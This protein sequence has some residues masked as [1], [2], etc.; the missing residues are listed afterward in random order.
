MWSRIELAETLDPFGASS[1]WH[2]GWSSKLDVQYSKSCLRK[3]NEGRY[4]WGG[5]EFESSSL[6]GPSEL[7]LE[8]RRAS[9]AVAKECRDRR[10][11]T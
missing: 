8:V 6:Y 9:E 5:V 10:L 11:E 7:G 4:R 2:G 3:E 1:S